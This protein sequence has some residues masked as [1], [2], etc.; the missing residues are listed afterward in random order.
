MFS[1][2][3][4]IHTIKEHNNNI[5]SICILKDKRLVSS[6]YDKSIIVYD[7]SYKS[8]IHIKHAHND[9]IYS[10]CVLRNGELVSSSGDKTIKVWK[11][12]DNHY[13]LI[14]T[15]NGHEDAVWKVIELKDGKIS[16]C[17]WDA[18]IKIW[19]NYKCIKTLKEHAGVRSIIE[20][21]NFIISALY[22]SSKLIMWDES[23]Y[24][25][26]TIIKDVE[27]Y[28]N[29]SL[30]KTNDNT[31]IVGGRAVLYIIDIQ[32]CK[33]NQIEDDSLGWIE[34][35]Y[36]LRNGFVLIGS[37]EGEII[38]YDLSSFQIIFK[39]QFHKYNIYCLI[40]SE[41]NKIISCSLDMSI[42]I[43]K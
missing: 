23:T 42:N 1:K 6:S 16:S 24:Q 35:L 15:L 3:K 20:I 31:L 43:Y 12:N 19:D 27:C 32:T 11:I 22:Y 13:I 9:Y 5:T 33:V 14:H 30:S 40:E 26:I 29:N 17:S 28:S 10:L 25:A 8:Q 18:T 2:L 4:I 41:D 36:V 37:E 21:K 39:Q 38:Y 7:H 34:C